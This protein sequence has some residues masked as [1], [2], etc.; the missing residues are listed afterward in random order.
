MTVDVLV[1]G[2]GPS[3]LFSAIELARHGVPALVV[4]REPEP[5][6]QARATSIQPGTLELLAR[7]GVADGIVAES[8][9][10]QFGRLLDANL[11]VIS[12]LDLARTGCRW[13]FQCN[14]PQWRTEQV[15][16][17]RLRELGITVQP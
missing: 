12:E 17:E 15:L 6:H 2:A 3:G 9:H 13:E 7:A 5:H 1:V 11:E 4:E 14:L 10:L 8:E 16:A